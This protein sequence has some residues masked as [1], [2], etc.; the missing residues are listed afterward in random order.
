M[1][2]EVFSGGPTHEYQPLAQRIIAELEEP[3][4]LPMGKDVPYTVTDLLGVMEI[5][6][7]Q[8]IVAWEDEKKG[9]RRLVGYNVSGP[10]KNYPEYLK[11]KK[12]NLTPIDG[13]PMLQGP[14]DTTWY[15]D[16]IAVI[17]QEQG[18]GIGKQM[19]NLALPHALTRGFT[20]WVVFL[21][22]HP[23]S[24]SLELYNGHPVFKAIQERGGLVE[25]V[26]PHRGTHV[27]YRLYDLQ[28]AV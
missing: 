18:K 5:P 8:T 27:R 1:N 14:D 16:T 10:Y 26:V 25:G 21:S 2:L 9:G 6:G 11:A 28:R 3:I 17:Q 7:S 12:E 20:S 22:L 24:R 4:F 15:H 23:S 13:G 19:L